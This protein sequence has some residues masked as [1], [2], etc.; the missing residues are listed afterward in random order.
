MIRRRLQS[1]SG[2]TLV[3]LL[4]ASTIGTV[5]LLAAFSVLDNVTR[6]ERKVDQRVD[7]TQ[8]SRLAMEQ[9][10]RQL[11][12]QV[13]LG[14]GIAPMLDATD[15]KVTF[16]ASVAPAA[17]TP[18]AAPLV[19]KRTL[20]YVPN[21]STGRGSIRETVIDAKGTA[22]NYDWTNPAKVRTIAT[23]IAP[24]AGTP[25]FQYFKYDPDLSPTVQKLTPP[26]NAQDI[27]IIVQVQT[28]FKGYARDGRNEERSAVRMDNKVTVRTADPTD[29]TRSPKCI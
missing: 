14:K 22:P 27:Q 6:A 8:S 12:A 4:V 3:E 21:G 26:I 29:P 24:V 15:Q 18:S 20:E 19:Q 17:S 13:C 23:E 1:E 25:M 28:T 7:A 11:R 16:Y 9:V 10:S 5:V 2:F